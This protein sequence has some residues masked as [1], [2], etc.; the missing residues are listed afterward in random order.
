MS[1]DTKKIGIEKPIE[2]AYHR[3]V[4]L[5]FRNFDIGK[6]FIWGFS[7]FVILMGEGGSGGFN[8]SFNFPSGF[9]GG[10]STP[11]SS[12]GG[13][14]GS[15]GAS[16]VAGSLL[17]MIQNFLSSNAAYLVIG[18]FLL[19]V[20]IGIGVW[21]LLIWLRSRF[22]FI[23]LDN[24]L[25]NHTKIAEPWDKFSVEG[26]ALFKWRLILMMSFFFILLILL[27]LIAAIV[28][29][30]C[31]EPIK[32]GNMTT[33]GITGIVLGVLLIL[34]VLLPFSILFSLVVFGTKHFIVPLMYDHAMTP[35]EAWRTLKPVLSSH[36]MDFFIYVVVCIGIGMG[37]GL[38][39][40]IVVVA[41]CGFCLL[42]CIPLL[43]TYLTAVATL[44][45]HVFY[46]L[47]S[48]DFV[49]Q[50]KP[51]AVTAVSQ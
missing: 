39:T 46:R 19:V 10:T 14:S 32:T 2:F 37:I 38:I 18:I 30:M 48:V 23:F 45:V 8:G 21:V 34:F 24:I 3:T 12:G 20:A 33:T 51:P 29:G 6:W 31:W 26:N 41:T 22:D 16:Q 36:K 27:A 17:S 5:C 4:E 43:G 7:A 35:G 28:M 47:F 13:S 15:G 49:R 42:I 50:F 44:P 1:G 9:G 25:E 40:T 11:T